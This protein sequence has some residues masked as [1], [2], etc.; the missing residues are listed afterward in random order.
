MATATPTA[1]P[2]PAPLNSIRVRFG[3][4][5][6]DGSTAEEP[7][8][9]TVRRL[10]VL[11]DEDN[12]VLVYRGVEDGGKVAV[13][14]LTGNV[15]VEGDGDVRPTPEDCQFLKLR[16]GETEFVTVTDTGTRRPTPSTRLDLDRRST[17]ASKSLGGS[18]RCGR[19]A[20]VPAFA[21][22]R[23]IGVPLHVV[24]AGESHGPGLTT[25]VEGLPAGLELSKQR[26]IAT[27]PAASSA[28]A[29]VGG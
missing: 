3:K 18:R 1:T 2:K 17:L 4:V 23:I 22:R 21:L 7:K 9:A 11:P 26:S 19:R 27:S 14:E 24:T 28:T 12:P 5:A 6:E 25:I 16:A 13:F 10:E 20:C 8:A 29:G 15:T